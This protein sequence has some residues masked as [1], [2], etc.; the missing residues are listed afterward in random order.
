MSDTSQ[1]RTPAGQG[2]S[3]PRGPLESPWTAERRLLRWGGVAGLAGFAL[4]MGALA[5]V[6]AL[7]LPDA[8]DVETLRD[9]EAIESGRIAE[10][11]LYLGALMM[12]ILHVVVLHR[13][14]GAGHLAASLFGMVVAAS[15]LV[16]MAASS[17]LHVSTSPLARLYTAPDTSPEEK[18]M[19]EYAWH[20]AQSVFDTMLATG[21]LLVPIG[22][23]LFGIA[24]RSAPE[25]GPRL[26]IFSVV[27]GGLG[28]IG[29]A[30]AVIDPGSPFSA[31]SVVAVAVFFL[32]TG[33]RTWS[34]GRADSVD[35]TDRTQ[36]SVGQTDSARGG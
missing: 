9:F 30:V 11:F 21:V 6:T 12:F 14:L 7:G 2:T 17:L 16:V 19:I 33:W 27:L 13:V 23:V 5:V 24:M 34:L 31:V 26:T 36:T 28:T 35:A 1:P 15:G 20:G 4:L 32:G 8:S 18:R 22:I 29:G 3:S 10:H 25:F